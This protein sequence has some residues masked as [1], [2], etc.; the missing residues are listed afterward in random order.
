[1]SKQGKFGTFGGVFTPS[2]L[3]ILGV[4]MYMRLGWVVGNAGTLGTVIFIILLAH[5]VSLTTGLSVSSIATDKKIKAGGIY[6]MLSRSL[7]FPIGG[8]IG[9]T[10]FVATALSISLYLIGFAESALLVMKDGLGIETITIN[11]LR[12][13]GSLSLLAIVTIA[14]ISTSIAIKAQY[15]ILGLIVLSL[16]SIFMGTSEGKGF[17][18]SDISDMGGHVNFSTLFG[19]F[20]PAVT[21]FTAGVAMSGDLRDP[22][23][24]IP[25]GTMLAIFTGLLVYIGLA[26]FIYYNIPMAELQKNYNVLVDFGAVG[27]LVT[28]GIWGATLSSALGG[29]L[30]A[31]R[32]LQAMSIDNI[33]PR[34]FAQGVGKDNEP[35]RALVL[36]FVIA[37][38]GILIGELD[39][40]AEIVAMFYMAAYMFINLS[41][42]LEQWAS[43]DFR[44]SFKISIF[45]PLIGTIVTLLLMIQLNLVAAL[46]SVA[47]MGL[48]F[49]WLTR[50]QLELGSGDVWQSVWSSIVKM[51]LKK[52]TQKSS[53][54]RNWKPNILLFSGGTK[55][56]PHLLEFG[57]SVAGR[58]GMISNFDLI[59]NPDAKLLFPKRKQVVSSD[60]LD[61]DSIFHRKQECKDIYTGIVVIAETYGFS[62][63]EPN[64]ILMGWARNT[65]LP[66]AFTQMT[67]ALEQL[68]YNIL[69]LDY[70]EEKGF[71]EKKSIDVWWNSLSQLNYLTVQLSKLLMIS[72][73]W[74]IQKIRFIYVSENGSLQYSLK[75]EIENKISELREIAEVVILN[76]DIE[77]KPLYELVKEYSLETDLIVVNLP[78]ITAN[79]SQSFIH[80]TNELLAVI[81]TTLLL[82]PSSDF[83]EKN[84]LSTE[85]ETQLHSTNNE[86]G[87]PV[88]SLPSLS[89][90][91]GEKINNVIEELDRRLQ[92]TNEHFVHASFTAFQ[93]VCSALSTVI[94]QNNNTEQIT[95]KL[96]ELLDDVKEHR[97]E[98]ISQTLAK[99]IHKQINKIQQH[100]NQLPT[101]VVREYTEKELAIQPDD[102]VAVQKQKRKLKRWSKTPSIRV[103][104]KSLAQHHFE[105]GY[106]S[107]YKEEL[108][109]FST[110]SYQLRLVLKKWLK[111][112]EEQT[113]PEAKQ[114]LIKTLGA[115]LDN[116][117]IKEQQAAFDE[118]NKLSRRLCN[119]IIAD[120]NKLTVKDI[121]DFR[122]EEYTPSTMKEVYQSISSYPKLWKKASS[123]YIDQLLVGVELIDKRNILY[124][125][126]GKVYHE[127]EQE[128]IS[129]VLHLNQDLT[130]KIDAIVSIDELESFENKLLEIGINFKTERYANELKKEFKE[131]LDKLPYEVEV[132][133]AGKTNL[134]TE[135]DLLSERINV[136]KIAYFLI[137]NRVLDNFN[138]LLHQIENDIKSESLRME[139]TVRLLQYTLSNRQDENN[140]LSEVKEKAKK[141]L[142]E[143][144]EHIL[145]VAQKSKHKTRELERQIKQL[146]TDD[147]VVHQA[148]ELNGVIRKEKVKKGY[149]KY[150]K[151]LSFLAEK[152]NTQIDKL[153]ISI[154]DLLAKSS[155]HHR[156]KELV[157]PHSV[158][159]SF[160]DKVSLSN[161]LEKKIPFYY[162]QL[163]TGK[164]SA[165]T[166]PLENRKQE[167]EQ[168]N[169]TLHQFQFGNSGAVLFTGERLCGATYLIENIEKTH[170]ELQFYRLEKPPALFDNAQRMVDRAFQTTFAKNKPTQ[171]ILEQVPEQTVI[172]IEDFEL[173]WTRTEKGLGVIDALLNIVEQHNNRIFFILSCNTHFYKLIRQATKIDTL[174]QETITI[175]PLKIHQIKQA[176]LTR[177]KSGGMQ[178]SWNGKKEKELG[179]GTENKIMKRIT[180]VSE[181]NIGASFY[182]WL[183]NVKDVE[184][185]TLQYETICTDDLPEVLNY[186]LDNIL[187]Q[188]LLHKKISVERLELVYSNTYSPQQLKEKISSLQR[189]GLIEQEEKT[190]TLNPYMQVYIT[191]YLRQR[192][193]LS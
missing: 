12:I 54:K 46:T 38:I 53:H 81:G 63:I 31:P 11:H 18:F 134:S 57:K 152:G 65:K 64:T 48:I 101:V 162:R 139:N 157:N 163:F 35:R 94:E 41:C 29:I 32:I 21:G 185:N 30:G 47:I 184:N 9:I 42:F 5:V 71:G 6:Y 117:L 145:A 95:P 83:T 44:P 164:H 136:R 158:M 122:E 178:F 106:L 73:D 161:E 144:K 69:F 74:D 13:V 107:A 125:Q 70:D 104:V 156:T 159:R 10:I 143:S 115:L 91:G 188:I 103:K 148:D 52:L 49:I 62:G 191:K 166:K 135:D 39:V 59:E 124:P 40:I 192:G 93:K 16:G 172:V 88:Y 140:S 87:K 84:T 102:S 72:D 105:N 128:H 86:I 121:I 149:Y 141:E 154:N 120:S 1:M 133:P 123:L 24:S 127:V 85:I 55:A 186:R 116:E 34:F 92:T 61:D 183:G 79:N 97:L 77:K 66:K 179:T 26:M 67:E 89:R 96:I 174:L 160:A 113:N 150:I 60:D 193:L 45:I 111:D 138:T 78:E 177:H 114:A 14:Y 25:W 176:I 82:K 190:L 112:W 146:L 58:N 98:E 187:L 90:T 110:T 132:V 171:Q 109:H 33:T 182:T 56:R 22:K 175:S 23:K 155:Y 100:L 137:E 50:K 151:K 118:L 28:A 99:E 2:I 37:E 169:K 36:T 119:S 170:S 108:G 43:P 76:N 19:V 168:F 130:Q 129:P 68:D 4:I 75:K 27:F 17:D 7:G 147:V 3:T 173:W 189:M 181:G 167:I 142:N 51:G 80:E 180:A 8:A 131:V 20:F 15:F 153:S 165:G 126:L